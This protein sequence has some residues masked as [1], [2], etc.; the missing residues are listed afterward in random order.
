[1]TE[2]HMLCGKCAIWLGKLAGKPLK[3]RS[4][5]KNVKDKCLCCGKRKYV[6]IYIVEEDEDETN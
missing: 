6:R 1:M 5:G 2:E 4:A 3:S